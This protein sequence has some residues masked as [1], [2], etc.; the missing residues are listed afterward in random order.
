MIFPI[1]IVAILAIMIIDNHSP[2]YLEER[3]GLFGKSFVII[4]LRTMKLNH[5]KIPTKLGKFLR[6]LIFS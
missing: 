5:S 3:S 4:K 6:S 2:F 1:I